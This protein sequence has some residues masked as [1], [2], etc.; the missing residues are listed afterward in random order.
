[1]GLSKKIRLIE[2]VAYIPSYYVVGYT[3]GKLVYMTSEEGVFDLWAYDLKS[4]EKKR[5]TYA[6]V[7]FP[8]KLVPESPLV[9]Y[10]VDATKGREKH[11]LYAVNVTSGEQVLEVEIEPRRIFR[12]G[13][14]G[15]TLAFSSATAKSV[16]LWMMSKDVSIEKLLDTDKILSVSDVKGDFITGSGL[17]RGNPR[18]RELFFYN[19]KS[20]DFTE[21]TVKE[22]S[23]NKGPALWNKMAL[24][25][26]NAYGGEKLV[27]LNLDTMD[28]SEPDFKSEDFKARGIVEYLNYG[29]TED[30]S[31]WFIGKKNGQ[32]YLYLDGHEIKLPDGYSS[33]AAFVNG[34]AYLAHSSL[35]DPPRITSVDLKNGKVETVIE[36]SIS[37]ELKARLGKVKFVKVKSSDG[38]EVPTFVIESS[39]ASKPGPT[40]V[41]VHGGPWSE[42]A[43]AWSLFIEMLVVSGYHV[44][45]PNFR[46]S[47]GYREEYRQMD[48]GDPG[49]GDLEDVVAAAKWARESG[50]AS[51]VAIMG[52][53]YGGFMTFLATAKK[54]DVWDAGVAGAGVTDW[55]EMYE[56]ADALFKKFQDTLFDYKKELWKDR[57][58][59]YFVENVK[60]PLCIIHPQND[61]RTPLKPVLRYMF[62]LSELGK[63]FE[64]HII[65]DIGH[66]PRRVSDFIK[67]G[68]P[69][70]TFLDEYLSKT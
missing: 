15:K 12:A 34:K 28:I 19:K 20:G 48:I 37:E 7:F 58:A 40:V 26:T 61:S 33:N 56:L 24:F 35:V 42:V 68:V 17:L 47:T 45:A 3:H 66:T 27:L 54:P 57:S 30:G 60:A 62:K 59:M 29:W 22:G 32:T 31:I 23:V 65:P 9:F 46:G 5:L 16:E 25:A 43:N 44:V 64:A 69:A 67:I 18:S 55:E 4:G 10:A 36:A 14:D 8:V 51:K 38:L 53:S 41:Y 52:Y 6:G 1:M 21:Y 13:W 70:V 11:K 39:V 50:L 49:G 2:E 63:T